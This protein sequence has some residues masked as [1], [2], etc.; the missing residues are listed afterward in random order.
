MSQC[1]CGSWVGNDVP[2]PLGY[3]SSRPGESC[4]TPTGTHQSSPPIPLGVSLFL[5]SLSCCSSHG[6]RGPG[7]HQYG[8]RP[9]DRA[10]GGSPGDIDRYLFKRWRGGR[11]L[12]IHTGGG[13]TS[14][15]P[16]EW[17]VGESSHYGYGRFPPYREPGAR[18]PAPTIGATQA[19]PPPGGRG[20][21]SWAGQGARP[22]GQDRPRRVTGQ[23]GAASPHG[24]DHRIRRWQGRSSLRPHRGTVLRQATSGNI[25]R[26]G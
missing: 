11:C 5:S 10:T 4:Y 22:T 3:Q 6:G 17:T 25:W 2:H 7:H 21:R 23:P 26:C 16:F 24:Q 14:V 18:S 15:T 20:R 13:V 19:L 1:S 9:G 8:P 12:S